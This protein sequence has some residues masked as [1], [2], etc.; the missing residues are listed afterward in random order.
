MVIAR[1]PQSG[2]SAYAKS[3]NFTVFAD[4]QLTNYRKNA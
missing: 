2:E 4:V 3:R 1:E